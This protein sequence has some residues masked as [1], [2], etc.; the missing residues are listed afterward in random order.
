MHA[1]VHGYMPTRIEGE[2]DSVIN[3]YRDDRLSGND[4]MTRYGFPLKIRV[5]QYVWWP[6]ERPSPCWSLA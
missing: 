4:G 2:Y 6:T 1:S 5:W 3:E